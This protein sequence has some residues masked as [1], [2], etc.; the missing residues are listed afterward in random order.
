MGIDGGAAEVQK[1]PHTFR[2]F[3]RM[4]YRM[5]LVPCAESQGWSADILSQSIATQTAPLLPSLVTPTSK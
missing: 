1:Q 3:I 5:S 4:H 2:G